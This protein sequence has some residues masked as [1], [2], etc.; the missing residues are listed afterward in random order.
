MTDT[1]THTTG[2]E[3]KTVSRATPKQLNFINSLLGQL[4]PYYDFQQWKEIEEQVHTT[5]QTASV[6]DCSKLIDKM[7]QKLSEQHALH[8]RQ[9]KT[10]IQ[11]RADEGAVTYPERQRR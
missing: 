5:L 4:R 8:P 10:R 9:S 3:A 6:K 1:K 11:R 7:L 2:S